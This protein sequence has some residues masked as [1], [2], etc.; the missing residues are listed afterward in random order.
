MECLQACEILSAAHDGELLD[1]ALVA[2]A[3]EHAGG[4]AE[5]ARFELLLSRLDTAAAPIAPRELVERLVAMSAETA[6]DARAMLDAALPDG[7]VV[8]LPPHEHAW[9]RGTPRLVA[10]ASAAAVLVVSLGV[11]TIALMQARQAAKQ[12]AAGTPGE[13]YMTAPAPGV[14]GESADAA[15][16]RSSAPAEAPSYIAFHDAVWV[17]GAPA[18]ETSALTTAGTVWSA[19]SD[20]GVPARHPAYVIGSDGLLLYVRAADGSL[21]GFHRV[22]R[23]FGR[24]VYALVTDQDIQQFG[25]WPPLPARFALPQTPDGSPTFQRF[26]FDDRTVDVYV[27]PTASVTEGFA[28]APGTAA[29]DPAAGNPG[30]TW[31]EPLR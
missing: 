29:E 4:C 18:V 19:L 21:L 25:Q 17:L 11:G 10:L 16:E 23:T 8:P 6:S 12:T 28:V 3:R 13:V 7:E 31:W 15:K 22:T 5:C 9:H 2:E 30:W 1:A 20:D 14:G 24:T 27:P 26:G